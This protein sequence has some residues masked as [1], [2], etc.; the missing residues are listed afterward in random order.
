MT[1]PSRFQRLWRQDLV[2]TVIIVLG[3]I[4]SLVSFQMGREDERTNAQGVFERRAS[5][6]HALIREVLGRYQD[7]M[8]GL[9]AVFT[10]QARVSEEEFTR[11]GERIAD[12]IAGI[13]A[14]EWVPLVTHE[15]RARVEVAL[16]RS[17]GGR[18]KE[19]VEF[20]ADGRPGRAAD[21]PMHY[22]ILYVQPLSGNEPALG[23]DLMTGPTLSFLEQ[24]RQT[25]QI[26]VTAP[27]RLVQHGEDE[28][29]VVMI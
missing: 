10:V 14:L 18:V 2:V 1:L 23:Y 29:G 13:Q 21:R 28:L 12:R 3:V 26:I 5:L 9:S 22:P 27:I 8:F 11:I 20:D 24:A 16:G 25:R 6:R 17:Y 7:T 15:E 4:A 19:F